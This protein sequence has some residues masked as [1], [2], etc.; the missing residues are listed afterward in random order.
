MEE[1]YVEGFITNLIIKP[2]KKPAIY[3]IGVKIAVN[4]YSIGY[5][6]LYFIRRVMVLDINLSRVSMQN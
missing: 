6:T 2:P 1:G 3:A 4:N 5:K